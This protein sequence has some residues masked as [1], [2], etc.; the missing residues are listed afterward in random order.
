[1]SE[2]N[3]LTDTGGSNGFLFPMETARKD[4]PKLEWMKKHG[5]RT[6]YRR[7]LHSS[8]PRWEAYIGDYET[9]IQ[10]VINAHDDPD[11]STSMAIGMTEQEAINQLAANRR[12]D[13]W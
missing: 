2:C 6:K 11:L 1:M 5:I 12:I 7:D 4:S 10:T 13:L 3:E 8:F 9:A